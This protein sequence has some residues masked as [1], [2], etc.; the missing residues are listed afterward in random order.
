MPPSK[1]CR[2]CGSNDCPQRRG[3]VFVESKRKHIHME[4][5]QCREECKAGFKCTLKKKHTDTHESSAG[6]VRGG[7]RVQAIW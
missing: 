3:V 2:A 4:H 7:E 5:R 1:A 6:R